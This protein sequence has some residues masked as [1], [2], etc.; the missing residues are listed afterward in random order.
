MG[1]LTCATCQSTRLH[2]LSS[3]ASATAA[4]LSPTCGRQ[5]GPRKTDTAQASGRTQGLSTTSPQCKTTPPATPSANGCDKRGAGP[6]DALQGVPSADIIK[7][8]RDGLQGLRAATGYHQ[9][10]GRLGTAIADFKG[11]K[12]CSKSQRSLKSSHTWCAYTRSSTPT[13]FVS[14]QPYVLTL[15][16]PM[17]YCSWPL[18]SPSQRQICSGSSSSRCGVPR[19]RH[20]DHH[21][22]LRQRSAVVAIGPTSTP[23]RDPQHHRRGRGRS[24]RGDACARSRS[25]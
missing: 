7:M 3:R 5:R 12:H 19:Q 24:R 17:H 6:H 2:G 21:A 14:G 16:Q 1:R 25:A 18:P 15:M 4:P 8:M 23:R 9:G 22:A 20:P 13:L 10:R 11:R